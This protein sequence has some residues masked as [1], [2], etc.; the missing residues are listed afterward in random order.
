VKNAAASDNELMTAFAGGDA[1]AFTVLYERHL[2]GLLNF[3]F[4]LSWDRAL[5]EDLTQETLI[6]AFKSANTWTPSAKFTTWLYRVARNL[7]IDHIRSARIRRDGGSLDAPLPDSDDRGNTYMDLLPADVRP[8]QEEAER[9]ELYG[10]IMAALDRLPEEQRIV[11]VLSQLQDMKYHEIA[12]VLEI[13]VGTVKS[14][15]HTAV[16]KLQE[17]LEHVTEGAESG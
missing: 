4:R 7:W 15:M 11:F 14:R 13:P 6:R 3:F 9:R 10:Q 16:L 8:P 17:L 12:E 5:A 1:D 2:G